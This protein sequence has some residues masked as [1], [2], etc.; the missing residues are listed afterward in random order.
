MENGKEINE[1]LL[2]T[3]TDG[4]TPKVYKDQITFLLC[5]R[6]HCAF[7]ALKSPKS[8]KHPRK[9]RHITTTSYKMNKLFFPN[10]VMVGKT[11]NTQTN[12]VH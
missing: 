9:V 4:E 7:P 6:K 12:H 1:S 8:A 10:E 11:K 2:L 3:L 5:L